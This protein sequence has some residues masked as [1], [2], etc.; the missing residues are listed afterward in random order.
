MSK[1][2]FI[3]GKD[4]DLSL[5]ELF[6]V[7]PEGKFLSTGESFVVAELDKPF[8]QADLNRFGGV[9]K[10]AEVIGECKKDELPNA[11]FEQIFCSKESGKIEYGLSLYGWSEKNLRLMLLDLKKRFKKEGKAS[12]FANQDFKNLT[13]PQFKGLRKK[14]DEWAVA[15]IK[16]TFYLTKMA[17][18]Q[19]I[20]AYTFR[21]YYKPFRN[22]FV[23]MLPPKLAQI[24]INLT[25]VKPNETVWDPF[26]G[27]G[28]LLMEGLLMDLIV[29]G[30]DID[31][32]ALRGAQQ[33]LA[34]LQNKFG[35]DARV[36]LFKHDAMHPLV[37]RLPT[38]IAC[39]GYLGPP[40]HGPLTP[41]RQERLL[42]QLETLYIRFF[43]ALK[44]IDFR[45]P[46]VIALPFFRAKKGG[47]VHLERGLEMIEKLGF[48]ADPLLPNGSGHTLYYIR[49]NQWVGRQIMRFRYS[50]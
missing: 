42:R 27:G 24:L 4:P 34:W 33:N 31:P 28:V 41:F 3:L 9:V 6:A 47:E 29:W 1:Y 38:V 32:A 18:V 43:N 45:G 13:V 37:G 15:K 36:R 23:G 20:D 16:N 26:C 39:E 49:E 10:W 8:T 5:A 19:D 14:G 11:L 30:S 48:K 17:G 44:T 21:D 12:R 50:A 22:M 2:L 7:Y 40:Q 35:L 46:V 25:Q